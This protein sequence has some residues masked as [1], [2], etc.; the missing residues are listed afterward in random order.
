VDL[1]VR[2][3]TRYVNHL[4]KFQDIIKELREKFMSGPQPEGTLQVKAWG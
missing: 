4:G 2:E 1:E 3:L